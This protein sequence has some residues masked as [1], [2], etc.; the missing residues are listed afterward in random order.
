[1]KYEDS[2]RARYGENVTFVFRGREV[3]IWTY[4]NDI[5]KAK[6][7][8]TGP[9][10][11]KAWKYAA[12]AVHKERE[13]GRKPT[14]N[15]DFVYRLKTSRACADC[16]KKY[17]HF[18]MDFDHARGEKKFNISSGVHKC[19]MEELQIEIA[20]CDLVCANCHRIRTHMRLKQKGHGTN[21][22]LDNRPKP[23]K[24]VKKKPTYEQICAVQEWVLTGKKPDFRPPA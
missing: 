5:D 21:E 7:L 20:K 24:P 13:L 14:S 23:K 3:E 22:Y 19:S 8:A 12:Y 2:V 18:V 15:R 6:R 16:R 11:D 17:P 10:L 4:P 1:M 9:T